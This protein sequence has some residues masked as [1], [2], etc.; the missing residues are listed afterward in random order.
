MNIQA[1]LWYLLQ[2]YSFFL[3]SDINIK[4]TFFFSLFAS[5][6]KKKIEN[7]ENI[8]EVLSADSQINEV[9]N[10]KQQSFLFAKE[11]TKSYENQKISITF[12]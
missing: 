1:L 4:K 2:F 7:I 12:D 5:S 8:D 9:K 10:E 3:S 6:S 11:Q